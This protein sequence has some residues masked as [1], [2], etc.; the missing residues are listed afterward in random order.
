L[1]TTFYFHGAFH[2]DEA[3]MPQSNQHNLTPTSGKVFDDFLSTRTMDFTPGTND[4][5]A[6]ITS[7]AAT[8]QQTFYFHRFASVPLALSGGIAANTW[9]YN[10]AAW[11]QAANM[12][13]P[14]TT[15]N[16][17]IPINCY[18]WRPQA[19]TKMGTIL[20]GNSNVGYNEPTAA[21]VRV[22]H[23]TFPGAAVGS[24]ADGDVIIME[25]WTQHTQS[26]ATAWVAQYY[27]DGSTENRNSNALVTNHAS[28]LETPQNISIATGVI[29]ATTD[30]KDILRPRTLE[31]IET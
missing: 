27:Q 30:N 1:A 2:A 5:I 10:F 29:T 7:N 13:W 19:Q 12:N 8:S 31:T 18:V 22:M 15:T 14:V 26:A 9:T 6:Q 24:L 28:F 20:Q 23:G 21:S 17:A 11:S 3:N 4:T 25:A 16:K